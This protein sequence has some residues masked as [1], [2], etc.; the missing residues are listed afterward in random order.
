[1]THPHENNRKKEDDPRGR[2]LAVGLGILGVLV[3]IV[4]AFHV[5]WRFV[6]G[7]FGEWL[8]VI[9]GVISTPFL[10]EIS[11]VILGLIIV[12]AINHMRQKRDGDDFVYLEQV[13][14]SST[15]FDIPD[16]AKFAIYRDRPLDGVEPAAVDEIEGALELG[17]HE[18]AARLLADMSNDELKHPPV[19]ALRLR[20]ARETG[21]HDLARRIESEMQASTPK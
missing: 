10:L 15:P 17:D 20:L 6:P 8:G 16:R 4:P 19:L 7:V 21:K 3:M 2:Q 18:Q 9:A 12:V 14:D 13:D 1:M 11:F 5:V